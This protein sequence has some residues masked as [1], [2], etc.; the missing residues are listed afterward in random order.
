M[1]NLHAQNIK[2]PE[3]IPAINFSL[4]TASGSTRT[5]KGSVSYTVGS[6]LQHVPLME[7]SVSRQNSVTA[8]PNKQ[9]L[10]NFSVKAYPN[11]A[12]DYILIDLE[13]YKNKHAQFQLFDF[14]GRLIEEGAI[15]TTT[16]K[17]ALSHLKK[18]YYLL[19]ITILNQFEKTLPIVKR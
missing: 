3:N 14:A 2:S 10:L 19:K 4:Q 9:D 17:V 15:R 6:F 8:K 16:T 13:D 18:S 5:S 1:G 11:P 7:S 12:T